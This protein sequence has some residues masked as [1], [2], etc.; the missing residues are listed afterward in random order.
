MET[1]SILFVLVE[2][3]GSKRPVEATATTLLDKISV[4]VK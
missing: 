2:F 4:E 1:L 3:C